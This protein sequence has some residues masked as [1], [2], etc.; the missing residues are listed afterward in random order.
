MSCLFCMLNFIVEDCCL[1]LSYPYRNESYPRM[2]RT[3]T[4]LV[5]L[6]YFLSQPAA[7]LRI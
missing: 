7:P 2:I 1:A 3:S 5:L 6:W 4:A